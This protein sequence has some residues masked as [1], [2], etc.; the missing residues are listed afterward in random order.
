MTT[1]LNTDTDETLKVVQLSL[2]EVV[3]AATRKK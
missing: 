3:N 1:L 2:G